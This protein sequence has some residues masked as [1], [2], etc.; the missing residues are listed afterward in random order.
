M[1]TQV[2]TGLEQ[3]KVKSLKNMEGRNW[4]YD[5]LDDLFNERDKQL[6]LQIPLSLEDRE[7]GWLWM[8]EKKGFYSV[9]S[10]YR[11]LMSNISESSTGFS[12]ILW[13]NIWSFQVPPRVRNFLW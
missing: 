1:E 2:C 13:K 11:M 6:I 12:S 8:E 9:K 7:D 3:V 5:L 10:G 4:D